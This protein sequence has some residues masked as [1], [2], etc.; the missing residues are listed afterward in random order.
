MSEVLV[1]PT[2][3]DNTTPTFTAGVRILSFVVV[4]EDYKFSDYKEY[5]N[6]ISLTVQK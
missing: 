2:T 6:A 1:K 3:M 5:T 4:V